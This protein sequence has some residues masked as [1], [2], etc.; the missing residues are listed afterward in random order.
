MMID[1]LGYLPNFALSIATYHSQSLVLLILLI[2]V[3]NYD[4][5]CPPNNC[6]AFEMF[7]G[8][9]VFYLFEE[10]FSSESF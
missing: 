4:S 2:G 10:M 7:H 8:N 9:V 5:V 1:P 6:R 3:K